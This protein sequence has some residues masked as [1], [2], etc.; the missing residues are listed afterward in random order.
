MKRFYP[1][2]GDSFSGVIPLIGKM[3]METLQKK[4]ITITRRLIYN[5][6]KMLAKQFNKEKKFIII[7]GGKNG[8]FFNPPKPLNTPPKKRQ[9]FSSFLCFG[10][11]Q[12][13][14]L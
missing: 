5:S 4:E 3:M 1:K 14:R 10:R 13:I 9:I 11:I 7:V 2:Q 6:L 8:L 12:E